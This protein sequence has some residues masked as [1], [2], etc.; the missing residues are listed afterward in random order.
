ME[1][2]YEREY[3][4]VIRQYYW[5][6]SYVVQTKVKGCLSNFAAEKYIW[7]YTNFTYS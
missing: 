5:F 4:Y 3:L 6:L 7:Y 2:L 1:G